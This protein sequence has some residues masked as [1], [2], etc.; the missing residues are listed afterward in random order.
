M[1]IKRITK[2]E[3]R[4]VHWKVDK[5]KVTE[6]WILGRR[7]V[8]KADVRTLIDELNEILEKTKLSEEMSKGN[9]HQFDDY[10]GI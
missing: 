2:Y 1:T 10:V 7:F 4:Y 3:G 5:R 9:R 6:V 8:Y